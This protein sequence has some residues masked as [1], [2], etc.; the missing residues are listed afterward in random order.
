MTVPSCTMAKPAMTSASIDSMR[1]SI[2]VFVRYMGF[3]MGSDGRSSP[4]SNKIVRT[5]SASWSA[6]IK[7]TSWSAEVIPLKYSS[8]DAPKAYCTWADSHI[9]FMSATRYA[10][11]IK[12]RRI[13]KFTGER[14]QLIRPDTFTKRLRKIYAA[15]HH[16]GH[17]HPRFPQEQKGRQRGLAGNAGDMT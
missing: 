1:N 9:C 11:S 12:K 3:G 13:I 14:G 7:S 16:A 6:T 10:H 8:I 4:I 15:L 5:H 2:K 17:L